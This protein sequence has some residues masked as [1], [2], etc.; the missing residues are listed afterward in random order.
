MPIVHPTWLPMSALTFLLTFPMCVIEIC[1]SIQTIFHTK[2]TASTEDYSIN[3]DRKACQRMGRCTSHQSSDGIII[4]KDCIFNEY[5]NWRFIRWGFKRQSSNS[6]N[7][8]LTLKYEE[9]LAKRAR[10]KL[11]ASN[12]RD[13][14]CGLQRANAFVQIQ[15]GQFLLLWNVSVQVWFMYTSWYF[16]SIILPRSTE[17]SKKT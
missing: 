13:F 12:L 3:M 8:L 5:S 17:Y 16:Y 15:T 7:T 4:Y 6:Y 2:T 1:V 10:I 14:E 11:T 9:K